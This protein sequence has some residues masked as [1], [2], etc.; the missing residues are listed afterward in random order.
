MGAV[1]C[2][3]WSPLA[4][5]GEIPWRS[6]PA[7]IAR[8][9]RAEVANAVT[10]LA[11]RPDVRHVVVQF[12]RPIG[13]AQRAQ[14]ADAGLNLLRYVGDRAF[15][16]SLS[17]RGPDAHA[18]AAMPFLTGVQGVNRA[19]KL[20]P[21]ISAGQVPDWAVVA[22]DQEGAQTVGLYV[23]FHPDVALFAEGMDLAT[24]HGA[25]VRDELESINGLVIELP[26]ANID[27]LADEDAVQWLEW[28]LPPMSAVNDSNRVV[29]EANIVQAAP[30]GLDGSGVTV[31][32][33]D[34]G[35]ALASHAD[36]G[37]RLTVRDSSGLSDHSTHVAGTI[38]G[39][40]AA[41]GGTYQGMAPGVIMQS[42]GF[43]YDG[44][45]IF[46]YS[47][48]GDIESDYS[49]AINTYGADLSNN[50]I[51]T[52]TAPNGFPCDITG[53]YGVTSQL[54]DTIVRGDG[55]NPLFAEPFRVVWAN[56]NERQTT[57][58]G[59]QYNTTA[60][61]ACAKNHIAVGALNSN[62]DSMTSFS[63]WGPAD[64]GRLKPDVSAPGCQSNDD[65]GVTST[66]SS[67]GYT[68][69]CGTSMASPTVCGLSSL[70]LEDF[71]SQFS[72]QPDFRNSTL[73]A[74][75]AHTAQDRGNTGPD[76]Q[77]GYGSVRIQQAID[78]MR[79]GAFVENSVSQGSS[80]SRTV[81]VDPGDPE[82]KVTLAWDDVPGTPN[83]DPALVN[84]LDLRVFS[85]TSTRHYP[86]T[87]NP[88]SPSSAAVRTQEDHLNNIEQ[89]LVDNPEAGT[90][91]IEVFGYD[92]PDGPQS[93]SLVG[94]GAVTVGTNIT[95]PNGLPSFLTPQAP[96]VIDVE[97]TS[98]GETTVPG[99]PTL[100][101]RYSGGSFISSAL[102]HV[103]GTLYQATLPAAGCT[104]TPEY[105]FS[106]QGS[107]TGVVFQPAGA[108][109]EVFTAEVGEFV[110]VFAENFETDQGW[111][112]VNLGAT[113]GDWQ[114]GVPVDD[115]GWAYDP[116]SDSDGSGQCYL[117]QNEIGN[118]DVDGGAVRL[119][120]PTIDMSAGQ[121]TISYDY[122]AYL[123][124]TTGGVDLLL[125]EIDGNDG[126]GPWIEIA[127]HDTDGGLSWRSQ[128]IEQADL[129]A[130]G[131]TLTSTMKLRFTAND[132][133]PQSINESGLDAFLVTAFQCTGTP[134]CN[135]G[136]LNQGEDRIDCGGP[137]PPCECTS[138]AAC[139]DG[140]FCNGTETCDAY[141]DCQPGTPVDCDDGVSCT[142]DFC[143]EGTDSCDNVA[144]DANCD[145]GLY[146]DGSETCDAVL[147]CQAGTPVDCDDGVGC[148]DD[149]CNETTD[150]CDNVPNNANCD[151]GLYCNGAETC[152]AVLDCQAGTPVDCGDGAGCTD[153]SCNET[154][155][156]CDN[157]ANNANCDDGQ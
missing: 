133:D 30:Y 18:L 82:L 78:F 34:G 28:P 63:S 154:T 19:W 153:D 151:D 141:G 31:L 130:A 65:F 40:G 60:P 41:S 95:F 115:P 17:G 92:V 74:W 118:T 126:A 45:G 146:C 83:V 47:N 86:W 143:N 37:G 107:I 136:I 135:D 5:R 129:D 85:P 91:T 29:T 7:E 98:V 81:V 13:P 3:A 123:T 42:Y 55:S 62:N 12:D 131:V 105:Y 110:T 57:R 9:N 43:Q 148:T 8:L 124:N 152:D 35:Y 113:S 147:D 101:Y 39:S 102:T 93:F 4:V 10:E 127:R 33:Y 67:G 14:L 80:Y 48:P 99:S 142:D 32:V 79:S 16:A 56:G 145:N 11:G 125:V 128:V 23:L 134:T 144:N 21:R 6:G 121:I 106:A 15:F 88:A 84:D 27:A 70:L 46:L 54:I 38:G 89:V 72:G 52:N 20:D 49:Q 64:D 108:P 103:S 111:S 137:C 112:A 120:S 50:S 71:R 109:A 116:A 156:T 26:R 97:V 73:K 119:I 44:S 140:Q 51:G 150:T 96:E 114:R 36:F 59:D 100:Y 138:D 53:N 25:L 155:D 1:F 24:R 75:L 58:C 87:L 157:V 76:Y 77:F 22:E 90:W 122:Y 117:T 104:D 132:A 2:V 94:D 61:P 66:S 149:S 139:S 69:K 68:V